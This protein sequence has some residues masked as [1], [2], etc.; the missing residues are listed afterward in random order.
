MQK[1]FD[2][3]FDLDPRDIW[4]DAANDLYNYEDDTSYL[5]QAISIV[6][7]MT[8]YKQWISTVINYEIK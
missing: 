6:K 8:Y 5:K 3:H 4:A 1:R 7:N 2:A